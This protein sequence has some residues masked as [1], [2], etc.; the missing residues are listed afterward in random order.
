[1]RPNPHKMM[2]RAQR[3][4]VCPV[5]HGYMPAER[6]R[7]RH[8][9]VTANLAIV[10]N[11]GIGHD[12]VVVAD[13]G[14]SPALHRAAVDG[15]KLADYVMVADLQPCRFTRVGDVLRRQAN[16]SKR[17][18]TIVRANCRGAFDR[19]VRSKTAAL[20]NLDLGPNHTIRSDL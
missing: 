11:V 3:P 13:P 15:D 20:A 1:M 19:D 14:A 12:Q 7:V 17:E 4:Y 2:H 6:S 8:N 10:R 5:F 9:D 16:R 18:E